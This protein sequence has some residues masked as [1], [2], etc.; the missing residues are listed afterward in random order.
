MFRIFLKHVRNDTMDFRK[1]Q[2]APIT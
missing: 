1:K 2:F